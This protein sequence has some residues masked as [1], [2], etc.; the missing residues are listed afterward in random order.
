MISIKI[1]LIS[2]IQTDYADRRYIAEID[3]RTTKKE[4]IIKMC[5]YTCKLKVA[6]I[7]SK[8]R[9]YANV[10]LCTVLMASNIIDM[11]NTTFT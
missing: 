7:S 2:V 8:T 3:R 5:G 9:S 4:L 6:K 1:L 10:K 11:L